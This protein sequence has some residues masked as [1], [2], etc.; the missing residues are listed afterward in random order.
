MANKQIIPYG[1]DLNKKL[2]AF[3]LTIVPLEVTL[4]HSSQS[5]FTQAIHHPVIAPPLPLLR[6][7]GKPLQ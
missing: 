5:Y 4:I 1:A 3:A 2:D 7:E 6:L